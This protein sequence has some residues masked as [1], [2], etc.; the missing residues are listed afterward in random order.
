MTD[1]QE[2]ILKRF[3]EKF[4]INLKKEHVSFVYKFESGFHGSSVLISN[5]H[6]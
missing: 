4:P 2:V 6:K 5:F 1:I 3:V